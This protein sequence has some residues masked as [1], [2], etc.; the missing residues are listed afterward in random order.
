MGKIILKIQHPDHPYAEIK[1]LEKDFVLIGRSFDSDI[2]C[3]YRHVNGTHAKLQFDGKEWLLSDA[4]ST[5]GVFIGKKRVD[6]MAPVSSGEQ[7]SIGKTKITFFR[8]D[9]PVSDTLPLKHPLFTWNILVVAIGWALTLSFPFAATL[10]KYLK[11]FNDD[12]FLKLLSDETALIIIPLSWS[13]VWAAASKLIIKRANF[14]F[15]LLFA[16]SFCI[17]MTLVSSPLALFLKYNVNNDLICRFGSESFLAIFGFALLYF[18]LRFSTHMRPAKLSLTSFSVVI[19]VIAI[20]N[21][22]TYT[23]NDFKNTPTLNSCVLHPGL[24]I[25][26]AKSLDSFMTGNEELFK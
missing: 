23:D 5:N 8:P 18:S 24:R 11:T 20:T 3:P 9:H 7:F 12:S 25:R 6:G 2:C 15:H 10:K 13:F 1:T 22:A 16:G 4:G 26:N 21:L 14:N 17:L 19:F